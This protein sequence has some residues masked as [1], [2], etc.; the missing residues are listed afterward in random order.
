MKII[1]KFIASTVISVGLVA[2]L[3]GGSTLLIE[4]IE[5]S[6]EQ[7]REQ[8]HQAVR[9]TQ[10]ISLALEQQISALKNYLLLNRRAVDLNSYQQAKSKFLTS[11][12]EIKQLMPESDKPEIVERR[13]QFLVRLVDEIAVDKNYSSSKIQQDVKA[14]NSFKDDILLFL[15]SLVEEVRQEDVATQKAAAEF[16]Q[17]ATTI[18]YCLIGVVLLIFIAQFS[19]TLLPVIRSIQT[20]QIGAKKLGMGDLDYRLHIHTG[21][22]IEQLATE[23]N[24]MAGK[25]A[26]SYSSLKQKQKAADIA[27]QAKSEFLANMSH[28]LRTPLNGILGYAQIMQRSSSLANSEKTK[29]DIIY[30]CASHLLTLINDILDLSKI[31]AGKMEIYP[32]EFHFPSLLQGVVEICQIKAELKGVTFVYQSDAE[33]P[34]GIVGDEKR[35]RQVLINL[36]SNAIKF[37]E[38]GTVTF[39]VSQALE[40]KIRFEVRDTGIGMTTEEI[41]HIFQAFEQVGAGKMQAEGTG[42]GLAISQKF[43]QLMGGNIQLES[44]AGVGSIFWFELHLPPAQEWVTANQSDRSG[45]IIGIKDVHPKLLIVDDKWENRSVIVNLLTPIGFE[46]I[47]ASNGEEGWEKT[48]QFHPDVV[49]TDLVMPVMDGFEMI[50]WIQSSDEIKQNTVVIASSASVFQFDQQQSLE[51]GAADFLPKP[52]QASELLNKLQKHLNL[53]WV[54]QEISRSLFSE[55]AETTETTEITPPPVEE[56]ENLYSLA[57]KGHFKGIIKQVKLIQNLDQKYVPF[58]KKVEQLAKG[59]EDQKLLEFILKYRK[60]NEF[61]TDA[62]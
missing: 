42:L 35:L 33:L 19:L 10:E 7:S 56:I 61:R 16:E 1:D 28:E 40:D 37:T 8:T 21:D 41:E 58:A 44:Q 30:K 51:A 25:L 47:E 12:A 5:E 54:Y 55:V 57:M 31:E 32:R 38:D 43:V 50:R 45:Q 52:I 34:T 22:E 48:Q 11:L 13:H 53:K 26:D 62:E 59:F 39:T 24:Q 4:R 27:N 14:I 46:V 3:L 9:T 2:A 20:L 23:F 6:V 15:N 17:N 60:Y 49:I 29:V 36:L 18:A